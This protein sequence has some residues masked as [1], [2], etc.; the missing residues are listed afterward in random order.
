MNA[1]FFWSTTTWSFGASNFLSGIASTYTAIFSADLIPCTLTLPLISLAQLAPVRA[2]V[3]PPVTAAFHAIPDR[4]MVLLSL[5]D[6]LAIQSLG[7]QSVLEN[8]INSA[9]DT[10]RA[11]EHG[12]TVR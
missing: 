7:P 12:V 9:D 11:E 10:V 8:V 1:I 6:V 3:I 4:L 5:S 2:S